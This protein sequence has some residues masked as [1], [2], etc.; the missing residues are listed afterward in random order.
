VSDD[1][2][3]IVLVT[4]KAERAESWS[5]LRRRAG[6]VE[7]GELRPMVEGQPILG[8]VVKLSPREEHALLFDVEVLHATPRSGPPQVA[9]RAYRDGWEAVFGGFGGKGEA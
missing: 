9:T 8:D 5:V 7:A 6:A 4:G 1:S 2:E 3:D